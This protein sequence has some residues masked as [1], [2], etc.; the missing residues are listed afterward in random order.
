MPLDPGSTLA[1]YVIERRLGAGGMGEV[2]QARHPRLPRSDALKVLAA[3]T[4]DD[5]AYRQRFEREADLAAQL[6]HPNIVKVHD[7]GEV[8]GQ[9]WIALELVDG[10]DL[11][12]LTARSGTGLPAR[13]VSQVATDVAAALDYA[14]RQGLL[15]R[16]VK[17]AN[18]MI[19]SQ[20]RIMLADFGIARL[21]GADTTALTS[22]GMTLG[23]V[24]Y[25]S[26]EQLHS[27]ALD[28]RSDQY[29]LAC[30]VFD[31]LTGHPPYENS[32]PVAVISAHLTQPAPSVRQ[33]HPELSPAVDAAIGRAMAKDPQARFASCREFAAH[34]AAALAA[35][36]AADPAAA[37]PPAG[38][39]QAHH[40]PAPQAYP[41]PAPM[42]A[43]SS[44]RRAW[45]WIAAAIAVVAV[46]VLGGGA[47]FLLR[48][49]SGGVGKVKA[50]DDTL[51]PREIAS[52]TTSRFSLPDQF[53]EVGSPP[54]PRWT[55]PLTGA[56]VRAVGG[57]DDFVV[58][59]SGHHVRALSVET[60]ELRWPFVDVQADVAE[61]ATKDNRI[62]CVAGPRTGADHDSTVLILDAGNG[63]VL[64][65]VKVPNRKLSGI[66]TAG[67]RF[68]AVDADGYANEK[69]YAVGY[70]TEGDQT[71][72]RETRDDIYVVPDQQML[73]DNTL[74]AEE[75][76][77]ISTVDGQEILRTKVPKGGRGTLQ[78]EIFNGG[79]AVQNP[80]W[81]GTDFYDRKGVKTASIAG[82]EPTGY[83]NK[84]LRSFPLPILTRLESPRGYAEAKADTIAAANPKTGHLLWRVSDVGPNARR[85]ITVENLV[86]VEVANPTDPES[87]AITSAWFKVFDCFTGEAKSP[88]I[89]VTSDSSVEY[90]W[91][92]ATPTALVYATRN[93]NSVLR[94]ALR[95]YSFDNGAQAW[96]LPL[97]QEPTYIG[98]RM[99]VSD[100]V[101][102][103]LYR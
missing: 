96:E 70:T 87:D 19:N 26:P 7:R 13:Q 39:L 36:G 14:H 2:Y 68:V 55:T 9:L 31:L 59:A 89:Q 97:E 90:Y 8:D 94:T 74:H 21:N 80:D 12:E 23:T 42:P 66:S 60:G 41:P 91:A 78:W 5:P 16:D 84:Y 6:S 99:Y 3:G 75:V 83:Q 44:A 34:L 98:T 47:F 76:L 29:S 37:V 45:P 73:V 72:E 20:G 79:I 88:P 38:H 63:Q 40:P 81:T 17:P 69:G 1:G 33:F 57:S 27:S 71:W 62:A 48:G 4:A 35:P 64:R 100:D 43:P 77:F 30:T 25:S 92:R 103:S 22:T 18:I 11:A 102:I 95:G 101:G 65:T 82:W 24:S 56:P 53:L 85:I 58:V 93:E 51:Y 32:N 46:L 86:M 52:L 28:G 15:H 61:C 50:W 49:V 54:K 67:D 10:P